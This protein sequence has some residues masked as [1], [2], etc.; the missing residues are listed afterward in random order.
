MGLQGG[1]GPS[2][3]GRGGGQEVELPSPAWTVTKE[4]ACAS[5]PILGKGLHLEA[6]EPSCL[7]PS[8]RLVPGA[9]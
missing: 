5:R 8:N 6:A 1:R 9:E 3:R 4:N 2:A 7:Q